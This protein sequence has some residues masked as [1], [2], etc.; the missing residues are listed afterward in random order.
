M[1]VCYLHGFNSSHRSFNYIQNKLPAHEI[2]PINFDSHQPFALSLV[3][4][5]KQLPK[6]PFSFVT[7]SL[8]GLAAVYLAEKLQNRVKAIVSISAPFGG[9]K[10]AIALRWVP[11]YPKVFEDITPGS[12][13]ISRLTT[14]KIKA[15]LLSIIS[16]G[17]NLPTTSEQND[18]VVTI[19]SQKAL[20]YGKKVEVKANHFEVVM[21][22]KTISLIEDFLFEREV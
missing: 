16:V 22:E 9:S 18:S 10:A 2:I 12:A 19:A 4:I 15:P 7:H 13:T 5:E 1:Q 14:L 8:G 20:P 3:D 17:G 6:T 21:H 11:G